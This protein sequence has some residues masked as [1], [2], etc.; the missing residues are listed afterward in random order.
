ME[1]FN[2]NEN[3]FKY[4]K[5][6]SG[7]TYQFVNQL[8]NIY[9]KN[10]MVG[11]NYCIYCMY[12]EFDIIN[13]FMIN[14]KQVDVCST[15]NLDL[16][17]RYFQIDN[18][19]LRTGHRVL[20]VNQNDKTQNDVYNVDTR[21]YLILS[22]ELAETGSTWRY[23]AYVKLGDNKGKQFHLKNSGNR[24][25]LKGERKDFLDGHGYIIKN[26]FNYDLFNVGSI[27]P[28]LIFT[29]YEIA[30]I[31]VNHNYDL[32]NGFNMPVVVS[33]DTINIKYHNTDYI[34]N[35]LNDTESYKY[36]YTGTTGN[37]V[38][39]IINIS[40]QTW[41]LTDSNVS[42]NSNIN[43]YV[44][45]SVTGL[46]SDTT[47]DL[48]T[49]IKDIDGDYIIIKDYVQDYILNEYYT[50][51]T[52]VD[53]LFKDYMFS[54]PSTSSQTMLESL[55]S[56]YFN[57]SGSTLYPIEYSNNLYVD[58]DGFTFIFS[59]NTT[60]SSGF[61]TSN[62]YIKYK[63]YPLLN[64]INSTKFTST[65][66]FLIP[67]SLLNSAYVPTYYDS[68]PNSYTYPTTEGDTKGTLI[69]IKPSTPSYTNYFK[70]YTFVNLVN[71]LAGY[72]SLIVDLVENEYFVVETYKSNSGLT[73]DSIDTIYEL[74]N[75]SDILYDV[76]I[77]EENDYYRK[78]DDDMRRN[79]CNA[80]ADFISQDINIINN[81][82]AFLTQD[83][84]HK[85]ILK[86]YDS[87]NYS[88]GGVIR[89]PSVATNP[90][91]ISGSTH[92]VNY[93]EVLEEGGSNIT[94]RG[95][96]Y[97]LSHNPDITSS[98]VTSTVFGT[99][100]GTFTCNLTGL[101]PDST[102]YYRAFATNTEGT[103]YGD[104]YV[105]LT[106]PP[107]YSAPFVTTN[108][109]TS[110][111]HT[112][113]A[114]GTVLDNGWTPI[115][116]RGFAYDSGI[117][118]PDIISN[119]VVVVTPETGI[120]GDFS[121]TMTGLTES[122]TYSYV[123]FAINVC[124]TTYG[125]VLTQDTLPNQPPVIQTNSYENLTYS[126]F[127][128]HGNL[129]SDDGEAVT[130][131]G[132]CW[133]TNYAVQPTKADNYQT[134]TPIAFGDYSETIS[135]LNSNQTYY[136]RAYC[137]NPNFTAYG[138]RIVITTAPP[139]VAPTVVIDGVS[140]ISHT[141]AT[142]LS[143]ITN[144]GGDAVIK[145]GLYYSTTNPPTIL[146]NYVYG[147][148]GDATW[149]SA[150][151][152]LT[153]GTT[154]YIMSEA[155]NNFGSGYTSIVDFT[156]Q[157]IPVPSILLLYATPTGGTLQGSIVY[158]GEDTIIESGMVI[159]TSPNPTTP[160]WYG[161]SGDASWITQI[162]GLTPSTY[163]YVRSYAINSIGIGYSTGSTTGFTTPSGNDVPTLSIPKIS[164]ITTTTADVASN[165]LYDGGAT[166]V[167]RGI[168]YGTSPGVDLSSTVIYDT[169]GGTGTYNNT[170]TGLAINSEYY[171][172]SFA[173]NSEGTGYSY[174]TSF[175]NYIPNDVTMKF[176]LTCNSATDPY[177][178][179][180]GQEYRDIVSNVTI[181][182]NS[183]PVDQLWSGTTTSGDTTL[184]QPYEVMYWGGGVTSY[185]N[186]ED[187]TSYFPLSTDVSFIRYYVSNEWSGI[188]TGVTTQT[189]RTDA[190]YPYLTCNR[191]SVASKNGEKIIYGPPDIPT[192]T[193]WCN[194]GSFYSG[195][196]N[197]NVVTMNKLIQLSSSTVSYS[198]TIG[199]SD[200][201]IYFATP[202]SYGTISSITIGGV[203]VTY[204]SYPNVTMQSNYPVT[205]TWNILYHVYAFMVTAN[206]GVITIN[207]SV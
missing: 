30:R 123:A 81:V 188:P 18:A 197:G 106:G 15:T 16:T 17:K 159:D 61:T 158:D 152:G 124:G 105:M 71:G 150:I 25:P 63:L 134:H 20:L 143:E 142:A 179:Q 181:S 132:F 39:N 66:T 55:Y 28:K 110:A 47:F 187:P 35:I 166:V 9:E 38:E 60:Q 19:N 34:I 58:Y 78:R 8:D 128:V 192:L 44:L 22:D 169:G 141:G 171:I 203:S 186:S 53:Y 29:D 77:N 130:E 68:R 164:N 182:N 118:T 174:E 33:G 102:Y 7:I 160:Q 127:K 177:V 5:C 112:I 120:I 129:I 109:A 107:N 99:G 37:L 108:G 103:G 138:D 204:S 14:L 147:G 67:F 172:K 206:S 163:Y 115:T 70:K 96:C 13:N 178:Y 101:Y 42:S 73:I 1:I 162:T 91:Y 59:G 48:K 54:T 26:F 74:E 137:I 11:A 114:Q 50:G 76:Y 80:Y 122:T 190:V 131:M 148:T 72:K 32:Y 45:L 165:V 113:S 133:N 75:I 87:E 31:S 51:T 65:Y 154:Y 97:S 2:I 24:F 119:N 21:G 93:G 200:N 175:N 135:G 202:A 161:T 173:I 23:K 83:A 184:S 198:Y 41:I 46:T 125:D 199:S 191:E 180:I 139:P 84:Q 90:L 100:V 126:S 201:L 121:A 170:I 86:L 104:E 153:S 3:Y 94:A 149:Y 151:T 82:T 88:N 146:D 10:L 27:V 183:I 205:N 185:N 98:F 92:S 156:T 49:Y 6:L 189:L 43:D 167:T 4:Q 56:N 176:S 36:I 207:Y 194:N 136:I 140:L 168:C 85:F 117:I 12:N 195:N 157:T 155:I 193:A 40:G 116:L 69:K 144:N 145:K 111:A 57:I 79:I 196:F 95:I 62:Y 89:L 64:L 52:A